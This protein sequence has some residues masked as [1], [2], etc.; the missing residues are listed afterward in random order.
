MFANSL[1]CI[2]SYQQ[3][4][5]QDG[6]YFISKNT[7]MD[8]NDN[9]IRE[10]TIQQMKKRMKTNDIRIEYLIYEKQNRNL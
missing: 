10:T 3:L 5:E 7:W 1:V 9:K 2:S 4:T 6:H 8:I